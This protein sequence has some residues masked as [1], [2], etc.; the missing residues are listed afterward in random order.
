MADNIDLSQEINDKLNIPRIIFKHSQYTNGFLAKYKKQ[1]LHT[2]MYKDRSFIKKTYHFTV[3]DVELRKG[4]K[5]KEIR[6]YMYEKRRSVD[7]ISVKHNKLFIQSKDLQNYKKDGLRKENKRIKVKSFVTQ[8]NLNKNRRIRRMR[9][10]I[11]RNTRTTIAQELSTGERFCRTRIAT[12]DKIMIYL[13]S[14]LSPVI[15]SSVYLKDFLRLY[16]DYFNSDTIKFGHRSKSESRLQ[17]IKEKKGLYLKHNF[18]AF[19]ERLYRQFLMINNVK[20]QDIFQNYVFNCNDLCVRQ[21]GLKKQTKR[22]KILI[23]FKFLY[24]NLFVRDFCITI[25]NYNIH[26]KINIKQESRPKIPSKFKTNVKTIFKRRAAISFKGFPF[27]K[28]IGKRKHK[29]LF[30]YFKKFNDV[31]QLQETLERKFQSKG[32]R[33]HYLCKKS[34][35]QSSKKKKNKRKSLNKEILCLF[36]KQNQRRL[37]VD[38]LYKLPK[39]INMCAPTRSVVLFWF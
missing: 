7:L 6:S 30:A 24:F 23:N 18:K 14:I 34:L 39:T 29:S 2:N 1:L 36:N 37:S 3:Q 19:I 22:K 21:R 33:S 4:L 13:K 9:S 26:K 38:N 12:F 20:E 27:N 35:Q 31:I 28:D 10:R 15:T 5:Q 11:T 25:K 17:P 32:N 16:L 8:Y